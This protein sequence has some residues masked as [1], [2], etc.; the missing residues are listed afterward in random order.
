MND[1]VHLHVHSQYSLLDG[2]NQI[3]LLLQQAQQYQMSSL[4]ITDHGNLFGAVEFY[5]KA[6]KAGIKPII[7]CETYLA[8]KSR[9][10]RETQAQQDDAYPDEAQ[11]GG[12]PYYHLILLA[13]N[14]QGYRNL[15]KLISHAHLEGFYYKPRIDKELLNKYS[16]GLIATSGCLR[17]EIPYLLNLGK[18]DEAL[19]AALQYQDIFGKENFFMELQENGLEKQQRI[20]RELIKLG[21]QLSIPLVA[22][23]DCHY[24]QKSDARAHDILLCLQTGKTLHDPH[25]MRFNTQELYF[26]SG[27]EM[28][29]LFSELPQALTNTRL[30][31]ERCDLHLSFDQF[32]L[33]HYEV[34]SGYTKEGYLEEIARRGLARHLEKCSPSHAQKTT[35]EQR[36]LEE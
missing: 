13:T 1:F 21:Q 11:G 19:R 30:I 6:K 28:A 32:H 20:N 12:T 10:D 5:Q 8:P 25:R 23:N 35:Y 2:A 34:P 29:R 33:P 3:D 14:E 26:K 31:A 4:A 18:T 22:T 15:V 27:E 9:F 24:L 17:G 36:L 7:G 16:Q